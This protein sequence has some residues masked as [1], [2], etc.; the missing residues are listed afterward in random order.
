MG[1]LK[2]GSRKTVLEYASTTQIESRSKGR[3]ELG[4]I[5]S[6]EGKRMSEMT[7]KGLGKAVET[8]GTGRLRDGLGGQDEGQSTM[9][10]GKGKCN[11]ECRGKA[12]YL[13]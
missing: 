1:E 4:S 9:G 7:D 8:K 10:R 11:N 3:G 12:S 13:G 2:V 5:A 6:S